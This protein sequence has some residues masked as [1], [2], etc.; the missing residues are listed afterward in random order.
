MNVVHSM[1]E[2]MQREIRRLPE[3]KGIV[4]AFYL[5]LLLWMYGWPEFSRWTFLVTV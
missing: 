1:V 2:R 4:V 5:H 3:K